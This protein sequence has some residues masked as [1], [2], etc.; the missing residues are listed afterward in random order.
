LSEPI[1]WI[2][3]ALCIV[4]ELAILRAAFAPPTDAGPAAPV[5]QSPRGLEMIWA[6]IPAVILAILLAATWRAVH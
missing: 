4:A 5:P 2:A 6:I 3:A 1:F